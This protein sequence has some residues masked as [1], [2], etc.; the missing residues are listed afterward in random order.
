MTVIVHVYIHVYGLDIT[1]YMYI[2]DPEHMSTLKHA[3]SSATKAPMK[4]INCVQSCTSVVLV[5]CVYIVAFF[6]N[7]L[8]TPVRFIDSTLSI[9]WCA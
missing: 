8:N 9:L 5:L 2:C 6:F 1:M 3:E 4:H 7:W